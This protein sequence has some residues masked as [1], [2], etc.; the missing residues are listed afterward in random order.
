MA[1]ATPSSSIGSHIGID[2][3]I[4]VPFRTM[5]NP[6]IAGHITIPPQS[7]LTMG[8]NLQM[9]G[10]DTMKDTAQVVKFP[11]GRDGADQHLIRDAVGSTILAIPTKVPISPGKSTSRPKP[12]ITRCI[13]LRPEPFAVFC[14]KLG[15]HAESPFQTWCATPSVVSATRGLC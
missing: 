12:T 11:I 15:M 10:V 9:V 14:G 6:I 7:I 1:H 5:R 3:V 2:L 8:Y 13:N 4:G